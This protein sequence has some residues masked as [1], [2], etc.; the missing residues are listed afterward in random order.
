[1]RRMVRIIGI[2]WNRSYRKEDL[3]NRKWVE[4][5]MGEERQKEGILGCGHDLTEGVSTGMCLMQLGKYLT[6]PFSFFSP[7]NQIH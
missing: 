4:V 3:G 1:M 5:R 6:R 2:Q 7:P